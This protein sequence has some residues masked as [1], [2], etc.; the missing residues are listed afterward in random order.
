MLYN[1]LCI[2]LLTQ[3]V[4]PELIQPIPQPLPTT[5]AVKFSQDEDID[6]AFTKLSAALTNIIQHTNFSRLQRA[7]IEKARSP[8]M[9]HKSAEII[10]VIKGADSFE[11]LCSILADTTYWN[12]LD[13]RMME[14]MATASMI[15]AAQE[16]VD[17]FKKAFYFLV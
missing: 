10:P 14:A 5:V 15:P 12:F 9:L 8:K 1:I 16:T 6:Y 4:K 2:G 17:N 3:S 7:C 13:I 11:G